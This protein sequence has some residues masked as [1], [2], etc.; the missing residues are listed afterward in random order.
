MAKN[1]LLSNEQKLNRKVKELI[2]AIRIE[3][4][5]TKDKILELYLNA[6]N[7]GKGS[8]GVAAA[9]LNY[10]RQGIARS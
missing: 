6:I 5:F 3:R 4:A 2:L 7:L 9:A 10:Y 8:Y 1:F